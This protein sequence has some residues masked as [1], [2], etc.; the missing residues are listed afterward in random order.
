MIEIELPSRF[1]PFTIK[2][3][4]YFE[5]GGYALRNVFEKITPEQQEQCVKLWLSNGVIVTRDAAIERSHE[6]CYCLYDLASG[7][8]IG[9]N[10]LYQG[11]VAQ[12]G[13]Q[14][15]LNRM[16][17]DPQHRSSRLMI[18][19]TAMMLCY[20]K[21]HLESRGLPG[22]INVNENQK[23]SRPGAA[24]IFRKLGYRGIGWHNGCEVIAFKFDDISYIEKT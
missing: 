5:F 14:A 6:V 21:T 12:G 19:G 24:S 23:L 18:V 1:Y 2:E 8:L 4:D 16:F 22:V 11:A 9:V 20:A 10:T 15:W 7:Q 17:I 3:L 13:V